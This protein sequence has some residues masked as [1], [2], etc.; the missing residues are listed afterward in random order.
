MR[1]V[2]LVTASVLAAGCGGDS[3]EATEAPP[4]VRPSAAATENPGKTGEARQP[5]RER[6]RAHTGA[7]RAGAIN[8]HQRAEGRAGRTRRRGDR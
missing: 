5:R 7:S 3:D 6:E 4:T 2:V 8:P 1:K